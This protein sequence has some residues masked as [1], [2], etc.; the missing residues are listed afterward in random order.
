[1][2]LIA[3]VGV[4]GTASVRRHLRVARLKTD[5]VANVS[6]ELRTPL[7]AM[8]VLVEG[9]SA[10]EMPRPE[11][12]HE[13]LR[14]LAAEQDRLHR[15]VDHFL[16]FSRFERASNQLALVSVSPSSIVA[17]ALDTLRSPRSSSPDI[18]VEVASDLP[19]VLG[20]LDALV[21]ALA[22]LVDNAL[23]YSPPGSSVEVRATRQRDAVA[24]AVSDNGI[25]IP[26]REQRRIFRRFYRIDQ[27][28]TRST[29]GVGLGLSIVDLIVRAHGGTVEVKSERGRGSTFTMRIPCAGEVR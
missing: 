9:L 20:D 21:T 18:R 22:N 12:V 16:T 27:Q 15:I 10:D 6:H 26:G 24:F 8:Q 7:A 17:T 3:V 2:T 5:L 28:L 13:Y 25:G 1:V 29:S 14:L 19:P 23:K 11:K 4:T